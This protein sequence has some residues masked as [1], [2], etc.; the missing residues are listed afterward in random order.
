M[1]Y[2]RLF[3]WF[4][5]SFL[6]IGVISTAIPNYLT[7]THIDSICPSCAPS[8]DNAIYLISGD[9]VGILCSAIFCISML[10][11]L[12]A[13]TPSIVR[14]SVL[15]IHEADIFKLNIYELYMIQIY[16]CKH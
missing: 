10:P 9:F 11:I 12:I 15:V 3:G 14:A 6:F 4:A 1:R 2:S 7:G 13:V 5:L 8:F 16:Q